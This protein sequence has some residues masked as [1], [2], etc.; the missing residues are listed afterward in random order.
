MVNMLLM[1]TAELENLTGLQPEGGCDDP[2]FPYYFKMKC[3]NCGE[4]SQ[5]NTCVMLSETVP[6]P[7]GRGHTNLIQRCKFCSREGTVTMVQGR[8]RP[9]MLE[10]S[11]AGIYAPL[12]MFDCRGLE[13]VDFSFG[14]GWK[15]ES[16]SGTK[17]GDIDLS[18][19]DYSEYCEKGEVPVMVSNLKAKFNCLK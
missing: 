10:V 9:L 17:F 8:G 11:Q 1:I 7:N 18:G 16:T 15:A 3:S 6:L 13:P 4:V 2:N 5:K 12:M 19:G 14:H